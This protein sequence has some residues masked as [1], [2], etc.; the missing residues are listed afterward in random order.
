VGTVMSYANA[1]VL[2]VLALAVFG[3]I[4]AQTL[5]YM[6]AVRAAGP[7]LDFTPEDLRASFRSGAVAAIGPSLAIVIVAVA[8][9]A[10]FGTPAVLVRIGLIGSASTETASASLAVETMGAELGGASYNAEAFAVAFFAMSLSGGMW[11]LATLIL[12]PLLKRGDVRLRSVNPALMAIVPSAALLAAFASLGI[13][14]F[15]K[16]SVHIITVVASALV[17]AVCLALSRTLHAA[18]LREWALGFSIIIGLIVA[19]FAHHSGL[20]PTA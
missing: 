2:W 8:L 15:G 9:L 18:W 3:V 5:I 17:M 16:S 14:E 4:I 19:Y 1:P 7:H 10:L 6:R 12:T 13:A 20:G 11:M